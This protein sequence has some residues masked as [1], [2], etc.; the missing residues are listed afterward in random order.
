MAC[1]RPPPPPHFRLPYI[2]EYGLIS[3]LLLQILLS[4]YSF[5]L[6]LMNIYI[7]TEFVFLFFTLQS[8]R[9]ARQSHKSQQGPSQYPG[10][11]EGGLTKK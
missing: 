5:F 7:R 3:S 10:Q 6:L 8:L 9:S 2:Y 4:S 1:C 11:A